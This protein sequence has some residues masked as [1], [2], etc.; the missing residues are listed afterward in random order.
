MSLLTAEQVKHQLH[1]QGSSLK[2]WALEHG[3]KPQDVWN[4]VQG[5][6]KA[7]FGR[8]YEIA[9]KLGMRSDTNLH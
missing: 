6:N 3:Y 5:R 9:V 2:K 4:V 1:L 8:G 7:T